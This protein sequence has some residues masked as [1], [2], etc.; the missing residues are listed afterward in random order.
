M[1]PIKEQRVH[2]TIVMIIQPFKD[3][4]IPVQTLLTQGV[5]IFHCYLL[6]S[7]NRYV[8]YTTLKTKTFGEAQ[9]EGL[10]EGKNSRCG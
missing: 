9:S 8:A 3:R 1:N 4:R 5:C 6:H 2:P 10:Y 7:V